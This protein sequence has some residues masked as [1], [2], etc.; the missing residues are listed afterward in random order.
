MRQVTCI[1][2]IC[3]KKSEPSDRQ[4]SLSNQNYSG[5]KSLAREFMIIAGKTEL[6]SV[7]ICDKCLKSLGWIKAQMEGREQQIT[8]KLFDIVLEVIRK[9]IEE[10]D[11]EDA[12][13]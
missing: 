6:G 3:K 4:L 9:V 12:K 2:D 1:C 11:S 7:D 5:N 8:E 13:R 10:R